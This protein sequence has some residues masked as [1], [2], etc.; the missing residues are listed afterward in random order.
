VKVI[1][2]VN[3][4]VPSFL[5]DAFELQGGAVYWK[6]G[7]PNKTR[8]PHDHWGERAG[9]LPVLGRGLIINYKSYRL[10]SSD[11]AFALN[12]GGD[13]PWQFGADIPAGDSG[14]DNPQSWLDLARKRWRLDDG[15]L[16][17][18]TTRGDGAEEGQ[19]VKGQL[20]S[21]F[22]CGVVTTSGMGFLKDDLIKLLTKKG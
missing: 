17:W 11:V 6:A 1:K 20:M 5:L 8:K 21:G 19:A 2:A 7:P 22:R 14:A 9:G 12:H 13:W 4:N 18:A 16:V 10:L 3:E 15:A